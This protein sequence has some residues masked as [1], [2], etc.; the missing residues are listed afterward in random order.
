MGRYTQMPLFVR[1]QKFTMR[2]H[3]NMIPRG[4][5]CFAENASRA[6]ETGIEAP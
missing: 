2:L 3:T 6:G 4:P 1:F 5:F